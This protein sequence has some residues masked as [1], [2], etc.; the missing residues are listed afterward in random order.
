MTKQKKTDTDLLGSVAQTNRQ[1]FFRL[2]QQEEYR[3]LVVRSA[4][5]E[6]AFKCD[7][8]TW[9]LGTVSWITCGNLVTVHFDGVDL[10]VI[11]TLFASPGS[12]ANYRLGLIWVTVEA[13][14]QVVCVDL[15]VLTRV[16]DVV[17]ETLDILW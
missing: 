13:L 9:V 12:S 3:T 17:R 14:A 10:V 8:I 1:L 5:Q 4:S 16:A 11:S 6:R 7:G 15:G 2:I